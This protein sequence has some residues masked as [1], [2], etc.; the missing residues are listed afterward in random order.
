MQTEIILLLYV[1]GRAGTV[2]CSFIDR[3]SANIKKECKNYI[4]YVI[5]RKL[6]IKR[7]D[8]NDEWA[9]KDMKK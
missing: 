7:P 6:R 3:Y 8:H 1:V 2:V 9:K 5:Y 4:L